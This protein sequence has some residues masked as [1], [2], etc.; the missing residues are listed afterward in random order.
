MNNQI[1]VQIL[2]VIQGQYTKYSLTVVGEINL[3]HSTHTQI[4]RL[5][6]RYF[7]TLDSQV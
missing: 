4:R 7:G 2:K 3:K 5:I 6:N 1:V